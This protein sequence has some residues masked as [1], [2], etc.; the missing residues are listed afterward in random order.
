MFVACGIWCLADVSSVSPSSESATNSPYPCVPSVEHMTSKHLRKPVRPCADWLTSFQIMF[1]VATHP[2]HN[3]KDKPILNVDSNPNLRE[4]WVE[5]F[6][7]T[8]INLFF[9]VLVKCSSLI[10]SSVC[11]GIVLASQAVS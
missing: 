10:F 11:A 6:P 7:E 1:F 8:W 3:P 5:H 2:S 9:L 4:V